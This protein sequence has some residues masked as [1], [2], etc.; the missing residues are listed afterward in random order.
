M[1]NIY[2][3]LFIFLA[4]FFTKGQNNCELS[5]NQL[6]KAYKNYDTAFFDS[7]QALNTHI[8]IC[9]KGRT[10]FHI[11]SNLILVEHNILFIGKNKKELREWGVEKTKGYLYFNFYN[12]KINKDGKTYIFKITGKKPRIVFKIVKN[13]F[14]RI[15][16]IYDC[17]LIKIE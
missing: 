13:K 2:L 16:K 17:E 9:K 10:L 5:Y 15:N 3:I 7:L 6:K 11:P 1:K 8:T 14:P 12:S 4:V